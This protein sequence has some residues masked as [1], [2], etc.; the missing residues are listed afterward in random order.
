MEKYQ[1]S[2]E[3]F[4]GNIDR[5]AA[6]VLKR[7]FPSDFSDQ[8]AELTE[9]TKTKLQKIIEKLDQSD[10]G[11]LT[12]ASR[13]AGRLEL[14]IRNLEEKVFQAH[15]KKNQT[16]T[17]QLEKAALHLYPDRKLQE[18]TVPVNYFIAKYGF[19]IVEFLYQQVDCNSGVHHLISLD[20]WQGAQS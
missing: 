18:R 1:L 10:H 14:E 2:F 15:K 3:E 9:E 16:V 19:G 11:L 12:T 8:F 7:S 4:T 6:S 13:T 5:L 17:A 20:D